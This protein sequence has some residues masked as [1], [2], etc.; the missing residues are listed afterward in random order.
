[1]KNSVS[2]NELIK[3]LKERFPKMKVR[4]SEDFDGRGGGLW[5]S[6]EEG[7]F[8]DYYAYDSDRKEERYILG[9]RKD[10]HIFLEEHGWFSEF[11][12]PGTVMLYK[13]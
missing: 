3:L 6:G 11:Y 8:F 1:M 5:T 2:R 4:P 9:T 13:A 12:D 10:V 7:D